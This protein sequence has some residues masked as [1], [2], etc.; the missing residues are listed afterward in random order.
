[1]KNSLELLFE[2][3]MATTLV[4]SITQ[5]GVLNWVF[6][7]IPSICTTNAVNG[8]ICP[9]ARIHFNGSILWIVVGPSHFLFWRRC[10]LPASDP[11][12]AN[13]VRLLDP[14]HPHCPPRTENIT[15]K[16]QPADAIRELS[17]DPASEGAGFVDLGAYLLCIQVPLTHESRSVVGEVPN[18]FVS[19]AE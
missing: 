5:I 19:A 10:P 17:L 9:P 1:M 12:F 14:H 15:T 3:Q 18:D 8:F 7:H 6:A 4:S 16:N 2:V 13:R 11:G